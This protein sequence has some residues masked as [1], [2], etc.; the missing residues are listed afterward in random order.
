MTCINKGNISRRVNFQEFI[1]AM[2]MLKN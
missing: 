2:T 1:I